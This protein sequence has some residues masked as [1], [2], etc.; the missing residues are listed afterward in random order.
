VLIGFCGT[1]RQVRHLRKQLAN[2]AKLGYSINPRGLIK[3]RPA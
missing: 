1:F 2:T 3:E